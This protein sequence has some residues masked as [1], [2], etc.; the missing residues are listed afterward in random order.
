MIFMI[1]KNKLPVSYGYRIILA[2]QVGKEKREQEYRWGRG[3][4]ANWKIYRQK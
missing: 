1:K 3:K 4:Q 2:L